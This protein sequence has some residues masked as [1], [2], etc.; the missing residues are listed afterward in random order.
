M[1]SRYLLI[2]KREIMSLILPFKALRPS[3]DKAGDVI[4]PPYDVL[5]SGEAR[6]MAKYKPVP[7][8]RIGVEFFFKIF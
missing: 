7:P 5:D 1:L 6:E 4:A 2:Y 3:I 8:T